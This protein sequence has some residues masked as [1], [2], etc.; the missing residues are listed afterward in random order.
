MSDCVPAKAFAGDDKVHDLR[1]AVADLEPHDVAQAL[2][3][4]QTGR[5]ALVAMPQQALMHDIDRGLRREI[6]AHCGLGGMETAAIR[7][8]WA[9][10]SR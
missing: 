3:V 5:P 9:S 10:S 7:P 6:F 4:R 8:E 1:R 2:L